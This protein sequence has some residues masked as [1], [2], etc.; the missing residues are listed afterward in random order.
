MYEST[1]ILGKMEGREEGWKEGKEEGKKEGILVTAKK[2][3]RAGVEI[4]TIAEV[5]GLSIV[6]IDSL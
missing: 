3:K 2:L 1:Y 5:T 4:Q 6:Q